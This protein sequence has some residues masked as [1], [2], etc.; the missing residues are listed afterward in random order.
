MPA[1]DGDLEDQEIADILA[2]VQ[3]LA[4]GGLGDTGA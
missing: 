3:A 4:S 1:F 2:Y